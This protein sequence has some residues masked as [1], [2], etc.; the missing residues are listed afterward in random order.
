MRKS[1]SGKQRKAGFIPSRSY[2]GISKDEKE[3]LRMRLRDEGLSVPKGNDVEIEGPMWVR[4]RAVYERER[5]LLTV[6]IVDNPL[7]IPEKR[8]WSAV[9]A[10]ISPFVGEERVYQDVDT[11]DLA[12]IRKDLAKLGVNLPS[13]S[14]GKSAVV[15]LRQPGLQ[16]QLK[17]R[18]EGKA[19]ELAIAMMEVRP[20]WADLEAIWRAIDGIV[21]NH[22]D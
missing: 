18:R 13:L 6:S 19:K 16:L 2:G 1:R 15:D 9:E 14:D 21:L 12:R 11:A 8:I 20:P 3:A 17:V 4:L 5:R 10:G 7:R 22:T